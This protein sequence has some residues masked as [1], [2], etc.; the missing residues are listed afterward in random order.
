MYF[1]AFLSR[2]YSAL[3]AAEQFSLAV[4]LHMWIMGSRDLIYTGSSAVM[5]E[6]R[7]SFSHPFQAN[8]R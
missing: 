5:P 2:T 8:V 4:T 7:W 3:R 1:A 6:V